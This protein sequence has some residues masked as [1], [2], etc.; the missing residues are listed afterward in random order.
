MEKSFLDLQQCCR[1]DTK[2]D[3][4]ERTLFDI[5]YFV[6][7]A[8]LPK[9]FLNCNYFSPIIPVWGAAPVASWLRLLSRMQEV[10]GSN[11]FAAPPKFGAQITPIPRLQVA[12]MRQES[13]HPQKGPCGMVY[14]EG[15]APGMTRKRNTCIG[16]LTALVLYRCSPLANSSEDPL[17]R[18][19][20]NLRK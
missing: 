14:A 18:Q 5:S 8:F 11:P 3:L 17:A 2:E 6:P 1:M 7:C 20:Y 10:R 12:M 15:R 9:S 19:E 16:S 4:Q 13:P